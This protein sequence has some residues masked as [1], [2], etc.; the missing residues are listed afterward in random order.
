[1]GIK[2]ND[3]KIGTS[4]ITNQIYLG[5]IKLDKKNPKLGIWTDKSGDKTKEVLVAVFEHMI[6]RMEQE[7][8]TGYQL[9][10]YELS[11]RMIE[12]SKE[13]VNDK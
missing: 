10:G 4:A 12:E 13:G 3:V 2:W 1:M 6:K 9:D 5:K 11:I 7:G 8:Y